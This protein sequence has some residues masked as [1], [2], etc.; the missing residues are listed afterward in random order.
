M[1]SEWNEEDHRL[2]TCCKRSSP[3]DIRYKSVFDAGD[4]QIREQCRKHIK[5]SLRKLNA[6]DVMIEALLDICDV[7]C[8]LHVQQPS[9]RIINSIVENHEYWKFDV[10]EA[11]KNSPFII[12]QYLPASIIEEI[13]KNISERST[14]KI[15]NTT[16]GSFIMSAWITVLEKNSEVISIFSFNFLKTFTTLLLRMALEEIQTQ[17]GV[18]FHLRLLI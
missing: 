12:P 3:V 5:P 1:C 7:A 15:E 11:L 4:P 2:G 18:F 13:G 14:Y 16:L 9:F 10:K 6:T 8:V 17:K